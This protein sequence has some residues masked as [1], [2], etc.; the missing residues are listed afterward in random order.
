MTLQ[1][2]AGEI[3]IFKL[4]EAVFDPN[5]AIVP[6]DVNVAYSVTYELTPS[7]VTRSSVD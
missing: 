1:V 4:P 7:W 6:A 2:V 5:D 3:N